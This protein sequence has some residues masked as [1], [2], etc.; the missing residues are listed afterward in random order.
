MLL[1]LLSLPPPLLPVS[2]L[3]LRPFLLLI[4]SA[5]FLPLKNL[6]LPNAS[7]HGMRSLTMHAVEMVVLQHSAVLLLLPRSF[8]LLAE[9]AVSR[10]LLRL[11]L[12]LPELYR[13]A[14]LPQLLLQQELVHHR[15]FML[16][17]LAGF[18]VFVLSCTAPKL[19]FIFHV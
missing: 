11:H 2:N 1:L 10:L 19:F 7:V 6:L 16:I 18:L 3:Q 14:A 15:M 17:W 13:S 8:L 9:A 12:V 4:F 5:P